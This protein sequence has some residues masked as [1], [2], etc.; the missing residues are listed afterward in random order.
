MSGSS[1][2]PARDAFTVGWALKTGAATLTPDD[3]LE[4]A[5]GAFITAMRANDQ[6]W[7]PRASYVLSEMMLQHGDAD[8]AERY[9]HVALRS[10]HPDWKP[11][12]DVLEGLIRAS[13]GD[14]AGAAGAYERAIA[15]RHTT[16]CPNA[17][18]N[19]GALHQQHGEAAAA[20]EAFR[21]AM[22]SRHREYAPRAAV[23]LGFVLFNQVRDIEGARKAFHEAIA[24][25]HPEQS[26]LAEKNLEALDAFV[27][28]P[29]S[30]AAVND[31]VD[32]SKLESPPHKARF[33]VKPG[34]D[35]DS[36]RSFWGK[37][38]GPVSKV[39][40]DRSGGG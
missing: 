27:E 25:G 7:S 5:R 40:P 13:R 33:L 9:L 23:N 12:A 10:S 14:V 31:T 15:T 37:F 17:R 11:A 19:L 30:W 3:D 36:S 2:N 1:R 34:A 4:S 32:V 18:F 21:Q 38:L 22:A 20:V 26:L 24:T 39:W 29:G 6:E 28:N 35:K 16:H 8:S